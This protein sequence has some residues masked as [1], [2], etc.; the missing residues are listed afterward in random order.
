MQMAMMGKA[1]AHS[2][3]TCGRSVKTRPHT[4][5]PST[6]VVDRLAWVRNVRAVAVYAARRAARGSPAPSALD[7]L[8]DTEQERPMG[9]M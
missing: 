6:S 4:P 8:T 3:T 1:A 7:T 9:T 5:R 2:A